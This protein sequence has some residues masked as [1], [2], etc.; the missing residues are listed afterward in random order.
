MQPGEKLVKRTRRRFLPVL[1][2]SFYYERRQDFVQL[3]TVHRSKD[4]ST[5]LAARVLSV[6]VSSPLFKIARGS[7]VALLCMFG[8][9]H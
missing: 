6:V 9:L 2:S 5:N 7:V 4:V 1:L 3:L 8:N